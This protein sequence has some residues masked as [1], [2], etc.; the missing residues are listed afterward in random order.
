MNHV[1]QFSYKDLYPCSMSCSSRRD[2]CPT[3]ISLSNFAESSPTNAHSN[4]TSTNTSPLHVGPE[5][6]TELISEPTSARFLPRQHLRGP[7][8]HFVNAIRDHLLD[9]LCDLY[10][11]DK[12][13]GY[14]VR[15]LYRGLL[16]PQK[17]K[18]T[19]WNTEWEHHK[20]R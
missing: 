15:R 18:A 10:K 20:S 13:F 8:N 14:G 2:P 5:T 4:G 7:Y 19:G 1:S 11:T 9:E 3:C 17:S 6:F 16:I 12:F